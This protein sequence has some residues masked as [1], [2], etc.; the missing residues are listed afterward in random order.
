MVVHTRT[1]K[2]NDYTLTLK[3][4]ISYLS[5]CRQNTNLQTMLSKFEL[6]MY[7]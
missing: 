5:D 6:E 2:W 3:N 1:I 4:I 7:S